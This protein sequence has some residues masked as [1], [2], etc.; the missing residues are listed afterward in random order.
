VPA[1]PVAF[2]ECRYRWATP[3]VAGLLLTGCVEFGPRPHGTPIP[4]FVSIVG[5]IEQVTGGFRI[6]ANATFQSDLSGWTIRRSIGGCDDG[7]VSA[8]RQGL[9]GNPALA[10]V[11]PSSHRSCGAA[12]V[13]WLTNGA[14]RATVELWNGTLWN[15]SRK[16]FESAP[17]GLYYWTLLFPY[18]LNESNPGDGRMGAGA[19][20]LT[21]PFYVGAPTPGHVVVAARTVEEEGAVRAYANVTN[22]GNSTWYYEAGGCG[23]DDE[24]GPWNSSIWTPGGLDVPERD[25]NA[26]D[27]CEPAAAPSWQVLA[28][29]AAVSGTLAWSGSL[30]SPIARSLVAAEPGTYGLDVGF[31]FASLD[32]RTVYR[33]STIVPVQWYG[34]AASGAGGPADGIALKG[35]IVLSGEAAYFH[36]N[37]TNEGTRTWRFVEGSCDGAWSATLTN[38]TGFVVSKIPFPGESACTV[39]TDGTIGPQGRTGAVFA[40]DRRVPEA[41]GTRVGAPPGAYRWSASFAFVSPE[42]SQT[43]VANISANLSLG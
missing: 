22:E 26:I 4:P 2:A 27:D 42:D 43:G 20:N 5:S 16:D 40:W 35:A 15:P 1:P 34:P 8:I 21:L 14:T 12:S 29:G 13:E 25:P 33:A 10:T 6:A 31:R 7:W 37:A 9:L 38:S 32:H 19:G 17:N 28:P 30:W 11:D 24:R 41:N 36:V 18:T 3:V 39:P 23:L